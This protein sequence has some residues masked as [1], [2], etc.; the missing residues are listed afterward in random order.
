MLQSVARPE[1]DVIGSVVTVFGQSEVTAGIAAGL[2]VARLR[3]RRGDFWVPL[4]IA[5]AVALEAAAK[6]VVAQPLPPHDVQRD[7]A[8]FPGV[9]VPFAHS[10]PSGHLARDAFLLLIVHGW[11]RAAIGIALVVVAV[12]RVY[13]GQHWPSDVLGGLLL[14]GGVAWV[15]RG[16]A[17]EPSV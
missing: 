8:F 2:A 1:L 14:G 17:Q 13:T 15:A 3:A 4:A 9:V 12:S 5:I 10:F 16:R 6:L 7:L 11:P